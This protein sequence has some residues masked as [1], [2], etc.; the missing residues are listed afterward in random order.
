MFK[1][2]SATLHFSATY[3]PSFEKQY[4]GYRSLLACCC[5][6]IYNFMRLPWY[7]N[8]FHPLTSGKG[9]FGKKF[10]A[11][12]QVQISKHLPVDTFQNHDLSCTEFAV[13]NSSISL[14]FICDLLALLPHS[15]LMAEQPTQKRDLFTDSGMTPRR[16]WRIQKLSPFNGFLSRSLAFLFL[17]GTQ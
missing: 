5:N 12:Q 3:C 9:H 1:N 4:S 6:F 15:S 11:K 14:C 13:T 17:E 10:V 7:M 16:N 8:F 2:S